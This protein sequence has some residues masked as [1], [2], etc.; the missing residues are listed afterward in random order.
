[1]TVLNFPNVEIIFDLQRF[2]KNITGTKKANKIENDSDEITI[3]ALGGNDTVTNHGASVLIKGGAG[4][5]KI[6]NN[7]YDVTINGGTGNDTINNAADNVLFTYASGD[8]NDLIKGFN[9][10]STLKVTSGTVSNVGSNGKDIFIA[11]GK[12][13]IMKALKLTGR[14]AMIISKIILTM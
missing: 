14:T 10:S 13:T 3:N 11:V 9:D 12:S 5:D 1:M 4:N 6:T 8:G 7:N 2:A